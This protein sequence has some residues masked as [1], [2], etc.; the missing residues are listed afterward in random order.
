[1]Q[2][3]A[4][5]GQIRG[6]FT[7]RIMQ[8]RIVHSHWVGNLLGAMMQLHTR[9]SS[10]R[11]VRWSAV[12]GATVI[13]ALALA[14]CSAPPATTKVTANKTPLKIGISLSLTGDFA[15]PARRRSAGTS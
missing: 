13:A 12:V 10:E 9:R 2:T 15:D 11:R 5:T 1:M 14:G 4:K 3:I 8:S 7:R 6:A